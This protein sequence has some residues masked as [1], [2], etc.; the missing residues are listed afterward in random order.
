[1]LSNPFC[2][3]S[4][5]IG[6]HDHLS[7]ASDPRRALARREVAKKVPNLVFFMTKS[8]TGSRSCLKFGVLVLPR[9]LVLSAV[10]Y[11]GV[12]LSTGT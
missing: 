7:A 9:A 5:T 10:P 12:L 11:S 8:P 6:V 1:M 4:Y 3:I 2:N